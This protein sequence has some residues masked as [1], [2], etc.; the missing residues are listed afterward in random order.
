M[1]LK[2]VLFE[3]QN[4]VRRPVI[5]LYFA[6]ALIFT[7]GSFAT[8]SL[9]VGEKEHIN[10]PY[11][12]A[13]WCAGITM[14]MMLVSSSIMGDAIYRDI[15]YNTKDYY[16]TYPIT[17]ASYFWGRF[18][19]SFLCMIFVATAILIGIYLGTK[20][21]PAMGWKDA[22][23]YGP[24]DLFF[25]LHPFFTI[26]LPNL[27]FT[28]ALFFGL[29]AVTRNVKVIYSGGIILFLGYFLSIFFLRNSNNTTAIILFDPFGL[30]GVRVLSNAAGYHQRNVQVLPVSGSF[31]LNRLLW[32]G[33]GLLVLLYTYM[34]FNFEK[35]FSGRRD[36]ASIDDAV[37][38]EKRIWKKVAVNFKNRYN[39]AY[40]AGAYEYFSR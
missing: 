16:L 26:A 25:Y 9:P 5:Y 6:A 4:R 20:I 17:K 38:N 10:S 22:K 39:R 15:E 1:F 12:I 18:T 2:I 11:L 35:F 8:G 31:L 28:S 37:I 24:N 27:I 29:V 40:Q 3:I 23:E 14:M 21:G 33:L 34:R 36:K 30:N 13:M 7:V 19:G 32:P